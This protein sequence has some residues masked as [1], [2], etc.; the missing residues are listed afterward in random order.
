MRALTI[1][2]LVVL[3]AGCGP[4]QQEAPEP[5]ADLAK[6]T[7]GKVQ[8]V[9]SAKDLVELATI[10]FVL[11]FC[12]PLIDLLAAALDPGRRPENE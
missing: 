5:P 12:A 10:V 6:R 1:P 8:A 3:L 9:I 4:A 7:I 2:C 11:R